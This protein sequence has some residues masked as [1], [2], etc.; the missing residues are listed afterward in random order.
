MAQT[1]R[2]AAAGPATASLSPA[3]RVRAA[4]LIAEILRGYEAA[5]S[6]SILGLATPESRRASD[7]RLR[8]LVESLAALTSGESRSPERYFARALQEKRYLAPERA[9][10]LLDRALE[11]DPGF[12]PA[13]LFRAE[14]KNFDLGD[15]VAAEQDLNAL[16]R[17]APRTRLA[18]LLRA[19]LAAHA[20]RLAEAARDAQA[21][22]EIDPQHR[23]ARF[24]RGYYRLNSGEARQGCEDLRLLASEGVPPAQDLIKSAC[25]NP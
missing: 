17:G 7:Q 15:A 22:V 2:P 24:L 5:L 9:V 16:L 10:E 25:Q 11:L 6:D 20:G 1:N 21:L 19:L 4:G 12:V 13:R 14:I 8:E 18:L 23:A 3:D